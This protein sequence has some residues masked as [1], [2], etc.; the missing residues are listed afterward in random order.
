MHKHVRAGKWQHPF[1]MSPTGDRPTVRLVPPE[2]PLRRVSH[3]R[4]TNCHIGTPD[5]TGRVLWWGSRNHVLNYGD[6][7]NYGD[8]CEFF[9]Y[10]AL[11]MSGR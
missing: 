11:N 2:Y 10:V 8:D 4:H 6:D 5:P 7:S 1:P 3:G 9:T